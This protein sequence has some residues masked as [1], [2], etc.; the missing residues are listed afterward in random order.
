MKK[1]PAKTTMPE[2]LGYIQAHRG[3]IARPQGVTAWAVGVV[4]GKLV[5]LPYGDD[6]N[7]NNRPAA[8]HMWWEVLHEKQAP[9]RRRVDP[10][11]LML[12]SE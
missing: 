4:A 2:A 12:Y 5:S 10:T 7:P 11:Q 3:H 8:E 9:R 6:F 1:P